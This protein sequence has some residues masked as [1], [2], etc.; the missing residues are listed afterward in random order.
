MSRNYRT[1]PIIEVVCEFQFSADSPWDLTIPGLVYEQLKTTFPHKSQES[2]LAVQLPSGG[3][4]LSS[5]LPSL[6][7]EDR[8]RFRRADERAFV[9]LGKHLLAI[10]CLQPYPSWA[11]FLPLISQ[12]LAAYQAVATPIGIHRIG[13]RYINRIPIVGD[14]LHPADYFTL[15]P[16]ISSALPQTYGQFLTEVLFPYEQERDVLK[17]ALAAGSDE[18]RQN[19]VVFLDFDYFLAQ[20]NAIAPDQALEWVIQAHD[21]IEQAFES[22]IT[23][24]LRQQFDQE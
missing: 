6:Q 23:D 8:M 22:C 13:L 24:R 3:S 12:S 1:P 11:Q 16:Q 5:L 19:M 17:I 15:Y 2:W 18:T 10:N 4:T 7:P 14:E 20:P 9:Q 21:T